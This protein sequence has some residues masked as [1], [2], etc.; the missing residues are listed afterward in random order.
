MRSCKGIGVNVN[1][2]SLLLH[3]CCSCYCSL[4]RRFLGLIVLVA[5]LFLF[6]ILFS[7]FLI[8]WVS[9]EEC[10]SFFVF[11]WY[12]FSSCIFWV[13]CFG[14]LLGCVQ[15]LACVCM[16]MPMISL[17]LFY[18]F[19]LF[20]FSRCRP[21]SIV[22]AHVVLQVHSVLSLLLSLFCALLFSLCVSTFQYVR[23]EV[24][25]GISFYYFFC[26]LHWWFWHIFLFLWCFSLY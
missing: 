13:Y 5:I 23:L 17:K 20:L 21:T 19:I 12:S 9:F 6:F 22:C 25:C 15:V 7:F 10:L 8:L 3:C 11:L 26:N 2:V 24:S 14:K 1:I 18:F 4:L 16:C